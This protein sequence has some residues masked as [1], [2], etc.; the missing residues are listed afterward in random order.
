MR[1][2]T[3]TQEIFDRV[4][5]HLIFQ[6]TRSTNAEGCAYRGLGGAM[7]AVGCL[8]RDE[9]YSKTLE[10]RNADCEHVALALK[11]SL[12]IGTTKGDFGLISRLQNL[13]DGFLPERWLDNLK[14]LAKYSELS[15]EAIEL[16]Q[17]LK[18]RGI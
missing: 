6:G 10:G 4:A 13:H 8:I 18:L 14:M 2:Y 15:V 3:L 5:I 9:H 12:P 17:E 11:K 1:K 7:C 16:A